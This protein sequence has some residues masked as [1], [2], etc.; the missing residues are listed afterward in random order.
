MGEAEGG[1]INVTRHSENRN[2]NALYACFTTLKYKQ[3]ACLPQLLILL[4]H[5]I[6]RNKNV[7]VVI[8]A[9]T[10]SF[11]MSLTFLS[12]VELFYNYIS[13]IQSSE[14][15]LVVSDLEHIKEKF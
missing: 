7:I 1:L 12:F 5:I 4:G 11:F 8:I 3:Y 13:F 6:V 14:E 10:F 15:N 9:Y 2:Y